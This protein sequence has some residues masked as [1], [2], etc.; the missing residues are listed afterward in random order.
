MARPRPQPSPGGY[1][2][3]RT[4]AAYSPRVTSYLPRANDGNETGCC[5]ASSA[6]AYILPP[7]LAA[8][9]FSSADEPMVKLPAGM[10]TISGHSGQS[11]NTVPGARPEVDTVGP[12]ASAALFVSCPSA[13]TTKMGTANSKNIWICFIRV[14]SFNLV[15]SLRQKIGIS[16]TSLVTESRPYQNQWAAFSSLSV[17]CTPLRISARRC[18]VS[19]HDDRGA[20]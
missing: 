15:I 7:C 13:V 3:S 8:Q 17:S 2:V 1:R 16:S 9:D 20:L 18:S 10:T 12:L 5:G 11:R 6:T 4:N 19:D 14:I